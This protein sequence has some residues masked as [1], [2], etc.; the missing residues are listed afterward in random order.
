[1]DQ[2]GSGEMGILDYILKVDTLR[3]A[4]GLDGYENKESRMTQH[5]WKRE[6]P[7]TEMEKNTGGAGLGK[8]RSGV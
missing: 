3:Y 1:M 2:S 6:L 7:F 4:V 8:R 5:S